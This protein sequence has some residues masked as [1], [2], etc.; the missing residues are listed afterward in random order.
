MSLY[1]QWVNDIKRHCS[2]KWLTDSQTQ[3]FEAI[4]NNWAGE[5]FVC[6]YGASGSGKT[7]IGHLLVKECGYLYTQD[8]R[9]VS[10]GDHQ[11]VLDGGEYSRL[12]RPLLQNMGWKRIIML[13]R[14]VPRDPM[15]TVHL[16]L[17]ERDVKQFQNTATRNHIIPTFQC[18][19]ETTDLNQWIRSEAVVRGHNHGVN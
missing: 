15:P 14:K 1:V 9:E 5:P 2:S 4:R 10:E 19:L 12:M 13:M 17:T 7:F 3:A 6:L 18:S 11:I 16:S 8:L